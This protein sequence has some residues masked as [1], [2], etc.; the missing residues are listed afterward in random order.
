MNAAPDMPSAGICDANE[1]ALV[2]LRAALEA[3]TIPVFATARTRMAAL[4]LAGRSRG[5][6][7]L[8]D[9]DLD[10]AGDVVA[11]VSAAGGTAIATGTSGEPAALF[12]ALRWGASGYLTK[13]LPLRAW[14]EAI[15]A[16][17]RGEAPITRSMT[18]ALV[19]E[20]RMLA[21]R[22][23]SAELLPSDRRLT[24]R[25]WE[26]LEL[27]AQGR[28]NR[29]VAGDLSISVQTVR[30]HVSNILAKLEAPNRSAAAA[31]YHRLHPLHTV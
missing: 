5:C 22:T 23:P 2:G 30:T 6:V 20:F 8:V 16:A 4:A 26:V 12:R 11:A 27:I 3:A 14:T 9:V 29:G 13:D 15:R 17:G 31:A 24:R 28:T 18:G 21:A 7:V 10:G 25:E 1:I 19:E